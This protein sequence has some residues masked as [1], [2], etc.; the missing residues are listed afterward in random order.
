L[1]CAGAPAAPA[2][3]KFGARPMGDSAENLA[4]AAKSLEQLV[5]Q[6]TLA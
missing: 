6:F 4:G 5:A 3:L 1:T 2:P